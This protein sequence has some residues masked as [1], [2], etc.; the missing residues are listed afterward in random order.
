MGRG[1]ETKDNAEFRALIR[2]F[3]YS[4][5]KRPERRETVANYA[6]TLGFADYAKAQPGVGLPTSDLLY[7]AHGNGFQF[8]ENGKLEWCKASNRTYFFAAAPIKS[9][10]II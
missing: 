7:D 9:Q 10:V 8:T 4:G 3:D 5:F 6:Y 2:T 1:F